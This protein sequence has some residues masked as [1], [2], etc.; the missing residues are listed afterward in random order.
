[1][2]RGINRFAKLGFKQYRD[3]YSG[4]PR[5][6]WILSL[7]EVVNRSG[8]MVFFFMTLY[9][10]QTFGVSTE[11]AGY[12]LAAYGFGALLGAYLGG[13]LTDSLGAYTVQKAS[14]L[15]CG[16]LYIVLGQ[17]TSFWWVLATMFV[18][19]IAGE[20]LH[21]ANS[22]AMSQVC[23]P[24]L[25]TKGFALNRLAANLGVTI[26]PALGGYLAL[27]DYGLLF[28]IDGITCL[29][30]LGVFVL[31]FKGAS[32]PPMEP[33]AEASANG[34]NQ[35][36]VLKD[37]Y[38]LKILAL[39]FFM[40][41]VFVQLFTTFPLYCK[42][43]Y[44]LKENSI[45]MLIAINTILI[46]LVEMILME[47]LKQ[48]PLIKIISTGAFLLCL[49]FGLMPL[50]RGFIYGAF[51]VVVWTVGEMLSLPALTTLVANHSDDSVRGKYMGLF[52]FAF[53]LSLSV[54]PTI[55]TFIYGALGADILWF[56][57]IGM[58]ILLWFGFSGL[59][60]PP[61][62]QAPEVPMGARETG[63]G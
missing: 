38:F 19:G 7:V 37:V 20:A 29:S 23:P 44:G 21:P 35:R 40:G 25:R 51:T 3:A 6:A 45:G 50:G 24:E 9:L 63:E 31:F 61:S 18:L 33:R 26:G 58:G 59:K 54:G 60:E 36:S 47:K 39:L 10:T 17:L 34:K 32:R 27:V 16:I 30:A 13:K 46:V 2:F 11:K 5:E 41:V 8:T 52:S 48:K 14:L 22:T 43:V 62:E 56:S 28:W 12:V 42:N 4:L 53:A 49:G 15:F 55:G 1:M 57:C